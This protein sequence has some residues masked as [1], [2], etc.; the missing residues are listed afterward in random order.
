MPGFRF[1]TNFNMAKNIHSLGIIPARYAS[2][3]FPGKPL[4]DI[5]GK[6]MIRRVYEQAMKSKLDVVVV[7]TDDERIFNHVKG[8]GGR[9]EMTSRFH[10]SGTD[11]CA[12]L[13]KMDEFSSI[14]WVVEYTRR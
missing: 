2:S 8:F 9:V 10:I 11:R 7:A 13:A 5:Q 4:V 12:E 6:S 14:K 3:R 1:S